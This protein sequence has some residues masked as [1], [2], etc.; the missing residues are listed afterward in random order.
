[1]DSASHG[2]IA[3]IHHKFKGDGGWVPHASPSS[4][5]P[6][7][8]AAKGLI[9]VFQNSVPLIQ[10]HSPGEYRVQLGT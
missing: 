5:V 6:A 4:H 1:M 10:F 8:Q 2:R 9:L 3:A 7:C